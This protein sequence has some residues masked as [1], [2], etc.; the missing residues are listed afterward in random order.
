MEIAYLPYP[1]VI[2]DVVSRIDGGCVTKILDVC[3]AIYRLATDGVH[4]PGLYMRVYYDA[5][6][7][8]VETAFAIIPCLKSAIDELIFRFW[9]NL[10]KTAW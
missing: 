1:I 3:P 8:V 5:G 4:E 2:H 9:D 7:N 10:A 6:A